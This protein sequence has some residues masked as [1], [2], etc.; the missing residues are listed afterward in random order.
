MRHCTKWSKKQLHNHKK[1]DCLYTLASGQ[2]LWH[3]RRQDH[4]GDT[5]SEFCMTYHMEFT[6]NSHSYSL[7]FMRIVHYLFGQGKNKTYIK[8]I[9]WNFIEFESLNMYFLSRKWQTLSH[10]EN[11]MVHGDLS[12]CMIPNRHVL[13]MRQHNVHSIVCHSE[14]TRR[15]YLLSVG[16]KA[17]KLDLD[18]HHVRNI[19][20][21]INAT[22]FWSSKYNLYFRNTQKKSS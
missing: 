22:L 17:K 19:D 18:S 20:I 2:I 21:D 5:N 14:Q 16:T 8:N 4:R 11:N 12:L 7:I 9:K 1:N 13:F 10:I 15:M 6:W 3:Q